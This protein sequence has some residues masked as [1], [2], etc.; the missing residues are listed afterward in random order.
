MGL[1]DKDKL[2][3]AFAKAKDLAGKAT[4]AAKTTYD[5]TKSSFGQKYDQTKSN[6]EQTR[7]EAKLAKLPQEGGIRRYEI[8]YKGG[9]PDYDLTVKEIKSYPYIIMDI[10]PDRFSFLAKPLS[11]KWF[12]GLE[13]TY[14]K[15]VT[16]NIIERII[17]TT[18]SLLGSGSD[19][20]DLR[21]KNVLEFTYINENDFEVVAR[22]EMLTGTTVMGQASKCVEFMD[23]LRNNGILKKFKGT[24]D[25]NSNS[26]QPSGNDVIEQIKKL[27]ELKDSGILSE[28]EFSAKKTELLA[29]I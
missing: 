1:F 14:D 3:G 29:K 27:S 8:T 4:D 10:M 13:I 16:I 26:N 18:E 11:E 20:S 22:F 23:L 24:S 15:I 12:K 2:T 6:I 19:N 17:S 25:N 21:Q 5:Q 28:E 9:L 7:E